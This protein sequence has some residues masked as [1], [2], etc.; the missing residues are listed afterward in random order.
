MVVAALR[1]RQVPAASAL[2]VL[3]AALTIWSFGSGIEN[4]SQDAASKLLWTKIQYIGIVTVP[5][6]WLAFVLHFTRGQRLRNRSILLFMVEPVTVL[7]LLWTTEIH[8]LFYTS[9]ELVDD[10]VLGSMLQVR[11]GPAFWFHASYSYLLLL[12]GFILLLYGFI[13]APYSQRR[14]LAAVLFAALIPWFGNIIYL[15]GLSRLDLTPF[16]FTITG[17]VCAWSLFRLQLFDLVPVAREQVI[18]SMRD[19]VLVLNTKN[20]IVDVNPA[21]LALLELPRIQVIGQHVSAIFGTQQELLSRYGDAAEVDEEIDITRV[22]GRRQWFRM[23]LTTLTDSAD[24]PSGRVLVLHDITAQKRSEIELRS[25]M[26]AA[27][28]ASKAKSAFLA[29][30]SHELRTPLNA[31]I[32]YGELLQREC[33]D[34]GETVFKDDL[35]RIVQS[36]QH[37]LHMIEDVLDLTMLEAGTLPL[38]YTTVNLQQILPALIDQL[39]PQFATQHNQVVLQIDPRLG[40]MCTD[41]R[42]L[43]RVLTTLLGNATKFTQSGTIHFHADS[44]ESTDVRITIRDTGIGFDASQIDTLFAPFGQA[45]GSST[46]R[47]GGMGIGL[48]MAKQLTHALG[49]MINAT[50]TPGQGSTFTITLPICPQ[51]DRIAHGS[52]S[53]RH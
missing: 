7:V 37:L 18:E 50:S 38:R 6:A 16:T 26:Q 1:H 49:G 3:M 47:H 34:R 10:S 15:S 29:N 14:Q 12:I 51:R 17:I 42:Q 39:Q 33:Q 8:K 27:E 48:S 31:I 45:D 4:A 2:A 46:R 52:V 44:L 30:M 19:A 40:E 20:R 28:V 25:A 32:G 23:R 53:E 13:R 41:Q 22:D 9:I 21:M 11:Y 43:Q 24:Q 35:D 5:H 36:G